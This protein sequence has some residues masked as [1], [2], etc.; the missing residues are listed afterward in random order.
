[1]TVISLRA[2]LHDPSLW[3]QLN[4]YLDQ[5]LDLDPGKR[6]SWL[7]QLTASEPVIAGLL[8]DLLGHPDLSSIDALLEG[9]LP[10]IGLA[11]LACESLAGRQIGAYVIEQLIGRGGMGEVWLASRSDGRFEG[12]CAIKFL[13]SAAAQPK[14]VER[15]RHEG[16]LLARLGHLNIAR[17]IDAGTTEDGR[18][19][20]VLEYVDGE[21]I[22]HY[23]KS[24]KLGVEA[25]VR[26]FLDVVSA[27]A[28]AHSHLI[29]HR[30]LKPS[31]VLVTRD[32]TVKLLDFGIAKLLSTEQMPDDGME[33]RVE[34]IAL[35]PEYAAPEQLLGETPSTATDVYQLGMLLYVLL[36]GGH[37]FQLVGQLPGSRAERIKAALSGRVPRA[38]QFA[39]GA[40][41]K[42]LR[43]DLDAILAMAL[44]SDASQRYPAAAA[45]REELVRYLNCEPVTARCGG[46]LYLA[47]KFVARHRLAVFASAVAIL[48][49]CVTLV[50]ALE[51]ARAA[52]AERDRAFALA[53][54]NAAVTEFL[55]TV[56]TEAA[57]ADKPVTVSDILARSEK[58][59]LAD[60]KGSPENRTAVLFMIAS[61][62]GSVGNYRKAAQ[63][64]EN[65]L[66]LVAHSQDRHLRSQV[67]CLHA[68]VIAEL[69]QADAA[70]RVIARELSGPRSDPENA[71]Y[72]LL[73]RSYIFETSDVEKV[74]R[75]A[76][77][78]LEHFR[79]TPSTAAV[80]E[81]LFLGAV[82]AALHLNGRNREANQHYQLALQKY[83]ELGRESGPAALTVRNNWAIF[84]NSTGA[85]KHALQLYDEILSLK[86][87][88][89]E[90]PP[91]LVTIG[92]RGRALEAI[93]R[94]RE[95]QA[96][97][98]LALRLAKE[99][100]NLFA[101]A[102]SL[103][104]LASTAQELGDGATAQQHLDQ[105]AALLSQLAPP[106]SPPWAAHAVVQ[107][108][109]EL[110][111]G[112]LDAARLRFGEVIGKDANSS[113]ALAA[114]L[115]R[116]EAELLAGD[117]PAAATDARAALNKARSLQ[118]D[119]PYSDQTGLS[120]LMLGRATQQLGDNEQAHK[121]FEAAV[122]HLSNTVDE[123][124]PALAHA[125]A[126]ASGKPG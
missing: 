38:S 110:A 42:E 47:R 105:A 119:A 109:I 113:R 115:G 104:G 16:R 85:P 98:E 9:V 31:N 54:R 17:L 100:Q 96:V 53:T 87:R 73:Y 83:I 124:H 62:Y 44:H 99:Q 78:A 68:A 117:A 92:N 7:A 67:N 59:A 101:Q 79:A 22:D 120:W 32:G 39:H 64:L 77:Q 86:A 50:F 60:T 5:V 27:V 97:Y 18:Q 80:D 21:R 112:R 106:G 2:A 20:L 55:G 23:C 29:I 40:L 93:G 19:F 108:R 94:Y 121:A 3:L 95:A 118:G 28:H 45:L 90:T 34:E 126:L 111:S 123:N 76:S 72:C 56:I 84:I 51:Q 107:G 36:C 66:S 61:R 114:E 88:D 30:D 33:T 116:A 102:H 70:E 24:N 37:P 25:R 122:S 103:L 1:M 12:R 43:G 15:F 69:G 74:L 82:A 49:L 41:K 14:L 81:G 10:S 63:L 35:T 4:G 89:P 125:R 26:L 6:R 57:E 58:L 13:N 11:S 8:H 71:A 91:P 52:T 65:A 75:Y 46:G 48:G